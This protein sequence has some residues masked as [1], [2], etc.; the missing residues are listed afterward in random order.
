MRVKH[1]DYNGSQTAKVAFCLNKK[2]QEKLPEAKFNTATATAPA[3]NVPLVEVGE[4]DLP[5]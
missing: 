1:E 4:D 3:N 2:N 5:F